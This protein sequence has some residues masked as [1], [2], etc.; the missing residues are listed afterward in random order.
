[1]ALPGLR[2]GHRGSDQIERLPV[3]VRAI[4]IRVQAGHDAV[5]SYKPEIA[6]LGRDLRQGGA[7]QGAIH[8]LGHIG[9]VLVSGG[10][11]EVAPLAKLRDGLGHPRK[12]RSQDFIVAVV[13][14]PQHDQHGRAIRPE[15]PGRLVKTDDVGARE[16][17]RTGP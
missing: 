8:P 15:R 1:M 7:D 9:I 5:E 2:A 16:P 4:E 11:R 10:D 3:G 13:G 17:V 14:R 6:F 12:Q